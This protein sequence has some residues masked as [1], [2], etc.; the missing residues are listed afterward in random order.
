MRL[1]SNIEF[2]KKGRESCAIVCYTPNVTGKDGKSHALCRDGSGMESGDEFQILRIQQAAHS[3]ARRDHRDR[4]GKAQRGH[5]PRRRISDR[6]QAHVLQAYALQGQKAHR[7]RPR[8]PGRRRELSGGAGAVSRL[9]RGRCDV[10]HLGL[11]RSGHPRAEHHHPRSGLGLDRRLDQPPAHLQPP[12]R[13]R[14]QPE[15]ARHGDGALCHRTDAHR[16]RRARRRVQ[17]CTRVHAP[18]HGE[19]P[20]RLPRRRAEAHD[21]AAEGAPR[22]E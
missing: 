22:R 1:H 3:P 10:P 14:P 9:V 11:R 21:P 6:C 16:A 19:G 18:E 20:G 17:P 7:L 8:A 12:D 15:I 5:D 2:P 4:R 13:R